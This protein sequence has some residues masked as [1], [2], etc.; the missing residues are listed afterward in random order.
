MITI[1][2]NQKEYENA[3]MMDIWKADVVAV[4]N[5]NEYDI[6]KSRYT[7]RLSGVGD[8]YLI[9]L[10]RKTLRINEQK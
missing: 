4:V 1:Y 5:G 7:E 2:K 6:V 8:Y 9:D 3:E 10:I